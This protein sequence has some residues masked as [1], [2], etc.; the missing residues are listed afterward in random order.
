MSF[1]RLISIRDDVDNFVLEE[2]QKLALAI[3]RDVVRETPVDTSA[4]RGAW[5]GS[6]GT[7]DDTDVTN[8]S[9]AAAIAQA[10]QAV[11]SARPYQLIYI[12]N[13]KPYI[14]RLNAG[15]SLQAPSMYIDNI[16]VRNVNNG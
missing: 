8:K 6:V 14:N 7:P 10:E 2:T 1:E 15:W 12:Q 5:L 4:A 11:K 13:T 3:D 16:I 9:P